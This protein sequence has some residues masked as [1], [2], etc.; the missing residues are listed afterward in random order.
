[1]GR[2]SGDDLFV[3]GSEP[4]GGDDIRRVHCGQQPWQNFRAER[5]Q[6]TA[7]V[8]GLGRALPLRTDG[9]DGGDLGIDLVRAAD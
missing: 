6:F 5:G 8:A 2:L 7:R 3:G 9:G 4:V 1:M